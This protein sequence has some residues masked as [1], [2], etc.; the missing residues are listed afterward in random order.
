VIIL[1]LLAFQNIE[2][3]NFKAPKGGVIKLATVGTFGRINPF[4]V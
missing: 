4:I 3:L 2:N 1:F